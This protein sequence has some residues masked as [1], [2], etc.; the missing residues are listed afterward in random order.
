MNKRMY[1]HCHKKTSLVG[2]QSIRG[3]RD[4][5]ICLNVGNFIVNLKYPVQIQNVPSI[6]KHIVYNKYVK[7]ILATFKIQ[8][9]LYKKRLLMLRKDPCR[10]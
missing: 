7:Y 2:G 1:I 6:K 3:F 10:M 5:K 4:V 9:F 8:L